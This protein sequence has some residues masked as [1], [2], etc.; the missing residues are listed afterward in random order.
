MLLVWP[1]FEEYN[2]PVL[3]FAVSYDYGLTFNQFTYSSRLKLD[4]AVYICFFLFT[5]T[6]N[7]FIMFIMYYDK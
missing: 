7:F 2:H 4:N 3:K 1:E 6:N 5:Q